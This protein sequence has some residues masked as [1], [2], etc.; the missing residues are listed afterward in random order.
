MAINFAY[1]ASGFRHND[2][3]RFI[4]DEVHMNGGGPA[5]YV[6]FRS[7]PW[8]EIEDQLRAIVADPNMPRSVKRACTWSALA[9]SVRA[10]VRQREQ[11]LY[12]VRR[13]QGHVEER[14]AA[15]WAL[16]S[17]LEQ[18]RLE[19]EA[20]TTQLRFT[21]SALQQA[22]N[23]RD[24][25]YGRLREVERSMQVY[26]MPQNFVP[27]PGAGQYA[28]V[29]CCLNAEQREAVATEAQ[30]MPHS[31]AQRAAPTAVFYMPEAQ[32]GWIQGM[33]PLLPMQPPHP[34]PFYVPSPMGLS[35]STLLPPPVVM[36]S[37]AAVAP[38]M[39]PSGT[40]PP[41]LWAT[42]GSQEEMTPLWDQR[43]YGQDG[44]PENFQW[45][46][47]PGDN[48]SHY[49][50]ESSECPQGMTSQGD[51]SSHSL[52]KDPVMH[53]GAAPQEFSKSHSLKKEPE[54]SKEMVPLGDSSSQSLKKDPV[55]PTEM[56]P[57]GDSNSHSLNKDP[58]IPQGEMVPL[59]DSNSHSLNKDP[60]IPQGEMVP[61]GDS[62]SHS[63]KK[64]TVIPQGE[65]VPLGDSN[66]HSL[67]KD[68]VIPQGEMV[69][70]GDSNSHSL[71]KD[72]VIPQGEMVP[73]GDS[74]SHSLKKD[75]VIPQGTAPLRFSNNQ[76]EDQ[77][78]LQETLPEDSK[79]HDLKNSP[80]KHHQPQG[81]KVKQPKREKASE[82]QQRKPASCARRVRW[83]C[84]WCN[85][86]NFPRRKACYKCK[87]AR[88]PVENGSIDPE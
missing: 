16:T 39:P 20:A 30:G 47:H 63:L 26:P 68:T 83:D 50:K 38:Q 69:P 7:R 70:L 13:L 71:K 75:P 6:A 19:R 35:D 55:M 5:F 32:S 46:Y 86:S 3:I 79:S 9:L 77:E 56:V 59:G 85:A 74:N 65:M 31:E 52:Q 21:Q 58:V 28:P 87:R 2:V 44:Y 42:V 17:Q 60:V 64:D 14:Q 43:C 48:R 22:L 36:E 54:R 49:Q 61:L 72:Q 66:S 81:Q 11:L 34:V 45:V 40:Y 4:N 12:Q 18:L 27:G 88:M 67:K 25:L 73:L 41:G 84:P 76:I 8:N 1:H 24:G 82:S 80:W 51:R 15:S 29:A 23:E 33:Q 57:L 62:N 37:A 53:Q 78:R 10:A